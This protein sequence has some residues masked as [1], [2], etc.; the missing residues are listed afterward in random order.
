MLRRTGK[1]RYSCLRELFNKKLKQLDFPAESFGLDSLR[2]GEQL[3]QPMQKCTIGFLGDMAT[4][5]LKMPRM[6]M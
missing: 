3:L 4:G 1:I 6:I 2:A 5:V